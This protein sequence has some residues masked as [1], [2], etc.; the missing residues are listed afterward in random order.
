MIQ[1]N[2][3]QSGSRYHQQEC[4]Q[5]DEKERIW[6]EGRDWRLSVHRLVQTEVMSEMI[7]KRLETK[8]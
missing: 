8:S 5:V 1:N 4:W 6:E 2:K 3:V 7:L